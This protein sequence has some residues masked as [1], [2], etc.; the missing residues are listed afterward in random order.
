MWAIFT[1]KGVSGRRRDPFSGQEGL[2]NTFLERIFWVGDVSFQSEFT[3]PSSMLSQKC[4]LVNQWYDFILF[5]FLVQMY[6]LLWGCGLAGVECF[7]LNEFLGGWLNQLRISFY[8][9]RVSLV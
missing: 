1:P 7:F 3:R 2:T 4:L 5:F 8:L 6:V 9:L